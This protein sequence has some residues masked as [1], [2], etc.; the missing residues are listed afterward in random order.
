MG[1]TLGHRKVKPKTP[2]S[3]VLDSTWLA[4]PWP[5][6][7]SAEGQRLNL[8]LDSQQPLDPALINESAI[9]EREQSQRP[10]TGSGEKGQEA[11]SNLQSRGPH[12]GKTAQGITEW[13]SLSYCPP[14][15]RQQKKPVQGLS[16]SVQGTPAA[17]SRHTLAQLPSR[18]VPTMTPGYREGTVR[19]ETQLVTGAK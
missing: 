13:A 9:Q 3:E 7:T 5:P 6:A 4:P 19:K 17:S 18:L 12:L 2:G 14:G 10:N 11:T 15:S 8:A 1:T 16:L